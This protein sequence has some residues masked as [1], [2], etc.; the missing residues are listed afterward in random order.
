MKKCNGT[1]EKVFRLLHCFAISLVTSLLA[2]ACICSQKSNHLK[3]RFPRTLITV[4]LIPR[5]QADFVS[6]PCLLLI[7]PT[8]TWRILL[9]KNAR[10]FSLSMTALIAVAV[11]KRSLVPRYLIM[12]ICLTKKAIEC[13]SLAG[14]M[15]TLWFLSIV[16]WLHLPNNLM[17]F[18]RSNSSTSEQSSVRE[19][20]WLRQ[21]LLR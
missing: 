14:V 18:V 13:L 5:K 1:N 16:A 8:M 17:W 3:R 9:L 7:S 21:R 10:M 12:S 15:E 6:H 20:N 11:R 19:E 4:S 2:K